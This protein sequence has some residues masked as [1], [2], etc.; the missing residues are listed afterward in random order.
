MNDELTCRNCQKYKLYKECIGKE[1]FDY[2]ELRF[3]RWQCIWIIEHLPELKIGEWPMPPLGNPDIDIAIKKQFRSEAYFTKACEI[4]AEVEARLALTKADGAILYWQI[5]AG[6]TEYQDLA[7]E[8]K[9]ALNHISRWD[10]WKNFRMPYSVW[11]AQRKY[12]SA[13]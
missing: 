13:N 12:K 6:K 9:M 1:W 7:P 5:K 10:M 4:A 2:N 8:S 3:C 11:K